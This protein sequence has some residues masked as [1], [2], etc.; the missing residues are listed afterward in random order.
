MGRELRIDQDEAP[1]FYSAKD[2]PV[3]MVNHPPH[4]SGGPV[5]S[6]CGEVIE[7]IDVVRAK[8]FAVGNAMKY[9][10]RAGLKDDELEDLRKAAW[11]VQDRIKELEEQRGT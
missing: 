7:C 10:W 3:D 4:Y 1:P 11:Y 5:H 8:G 2:G 6:H 9:L